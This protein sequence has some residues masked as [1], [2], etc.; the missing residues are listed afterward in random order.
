MAE[1]KDPALTDAPAR[2]CS[3]CDREMTHY[4]VFVSPTDEERP[5]CWQCL[6]R[7]E[8]GLTLSGIFHDRRGEGS[9]RGNYF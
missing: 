6:A 5:I 2:R 3:Q 9:F 4:N 1:Q 7:E 8:K